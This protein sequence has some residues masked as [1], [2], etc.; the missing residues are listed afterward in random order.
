MYSGLDIIHKNVYLKGDK[1][2]GDKIV[3]KVV[4]IALIFLILVP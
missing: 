2:K 4:E 1:M 3:I